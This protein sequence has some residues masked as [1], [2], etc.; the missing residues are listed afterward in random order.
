MHCAFYQ[1]LPVQPLQATAKTAC[2][3]QLVHR[4]L[5]NY[6]SRAPGGWQWR[7]WQIWQILQGTRCMGRMPLH[8]SLP[9]AL[10]NWLM[11]PR[12]ATAGLSGVRLMHIH[13][14]TM[15][16]QLDWEGSTC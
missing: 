3:G 16:M 13:T 14:S 12:P 15:E 1:W 11:P 7:G 6:A 2:S 5:R 8:Y 9:M 10:K 4:R